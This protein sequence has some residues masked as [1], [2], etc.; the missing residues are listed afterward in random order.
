[1]DSTAQTADTARTP[2]RF[3][4]DCK[5]CD[6]VTPGMQWRCDAPQAQRDDLV[7]GTP[8][9]AYCIVERQSGAGC[10][11]NAAYFEAR[12]GAEGSK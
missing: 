10:G 8:A 2:P 9:I 1:M 6:R 11:A 7:T 3:C 5:H 4:R 12:D